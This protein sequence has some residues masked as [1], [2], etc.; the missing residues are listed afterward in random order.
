MY[1]SLWIGL[2]VAVGAPGAKDPPKKEASI[3]GV[4]VREKLTANGKD[5]SEHAAGARFT[6]TE[7]GKFL[8]KQKDREER[9]EGTYKVDPK[10]D[11]AEIDLMGRGGKKDSPFP[12]IYKLDGDTLTIC[13][14]KGGATRPT[15]FESPEGSELILMTF[16]RAKKE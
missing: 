16:K 10:K 7:D 9:D 12:G 11:P 5:E 1:A 4:W 14:L 13:I 15:K 3:V 6:F 8:M 2:A